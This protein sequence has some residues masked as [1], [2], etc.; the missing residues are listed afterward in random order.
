MILF[1]AAAAYLLR[2]TKSQAEPPAITVPPFE[3]INGDEKWAR[4]AIALT[5]DIVT[6][7]AGFRDFPV[8]A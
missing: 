6:D 3:K 8:I 5:D 1:A 2:L 7:V 4:F